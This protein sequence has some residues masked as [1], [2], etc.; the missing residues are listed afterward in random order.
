LLAK[1]KLALIAA[2][3]LGALGLGGAG[4]AAANGALPMNPITAL[5]FQRATPRR[6]VPARPARPRLASRITHG[7]VILN[8]NGSWATYTLDVGTV[9][10]AS[11]SSL[12]LLRVDGQSVTFTVSASTLWGAKDRTPK[13]FAKLVGRRVAVLSQRGAAVHVGGRGMFRGF[14]YADLTVMRGGKTREI[15]LDRG[16]VKSVSGAQ[17]SLTRADGVA[18]TATLAP[19][20][21][22]RR[23]GVKGSAQASAVTPGEMV[24]LVV[25]NNQV[26]AVRIAPA[27]GA[28]PATTAASASN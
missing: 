9:T 5:S 23:A 24:T 21:R 27:Q 17:I 8:A 11:S 26:I 25:Y 16:L 13:D 3:L 19:N 4:V 10:A 22:Y 12:T 2:A 15:Q 14:A 18:V 28:E 20:V 7:A 6:G 1:Y